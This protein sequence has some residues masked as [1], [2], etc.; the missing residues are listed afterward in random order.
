MRNRENDEMR[1]QAK[2]VFQSMS[3]YTP[4]KQIEDVKKNMA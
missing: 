3:P 4:G 1:I 2:Q